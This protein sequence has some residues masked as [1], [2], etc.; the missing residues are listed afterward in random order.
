MQLVRESLRFTAGA[1]FY[2]RAGK[3]AA[4]KTDKVLFHTESTTPK[5]RRSVDPFDPEGEPVVHRTFKAIARRSSSCFQ[6]VSR[7]K[8]EKV[9]SIH[10]KFPCVG[11]YVP[12]YKAVDK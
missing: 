9:T 10:G 6:A 1:R 5:H 7:L 4:A 12:N 3:V 8:R 11:Q 2:S